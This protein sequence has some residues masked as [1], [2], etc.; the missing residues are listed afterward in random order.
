MMREVCEL[1]I[2]ARVCWPKQHA[3]MHGQIGRTVTFD[4]DKGGVASAEVQRHAS[5]LCVRGRADGKCGSEPGYRE[6]AP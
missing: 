4:I 6:I 2:A 3:W 1:P 5:H